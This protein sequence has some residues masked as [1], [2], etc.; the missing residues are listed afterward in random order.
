MFRKNSK[1]DVYFMNGVLPISVII[2]SEIIYYNYNGPNSK[3][4]WW[5]Y[6]IVN[7][8]VLMRSFLFLLEAKR[9]YKKSLKIK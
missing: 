8:I 2:I 6:H 1:F 3:I 4:V 5:L 9:D 7:L